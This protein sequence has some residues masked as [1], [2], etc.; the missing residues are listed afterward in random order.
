MRTNDI[1]DKGTVSRRT[2][3]KVFGAAAGLSAVGLPIRSTWAATPELGIVS[4]PGPSVSSHSKCII[5]ARD[6]D[7]KHGWNLQTIIRPTA[8]AYYNDFVTGVYGSIDFG[9]LSIFAKLYGK[10][11]PL[12]VVQ[13]TALW[14]SPVVVRA[15][16]GINKIQDLAGKRLGLQFGSFVYAY[17]S[18]AF[19]GAGMSLEKDVTAS[20]VGFFQAP[21]RFKAGDFDAVTMLFAHA[22]GL[23][24]EAPGT[25]KILMD[26][27]VAFAKAL[28]IERAY[29]YQAVRKDWLDANPGAIEQVI[30]TYAD[31]SHVFQTDAEAVVA[32]LAKAK[33][34]GGVGLAEKIG[35]VEYVTGTPD[36]LKIAWV[37][38]PVAP[39]QDG[40]M[41]ELEAYKKFGLIDSVPD[42]GLFYGIG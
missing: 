6:L 40:L 7:K 39:M 13:A 8:A 36:G 11:V 23:L 33:D 29:Q 15:D 42:K 17:M 35:K 3:L 9:G 2:A 16:S 34:V 21:P 24:Q 12:K 10:G 14:P 32:Q 18:G 19:Q 22:I 4:F 27:S 26:S 37:S 28:G 25:Y 31:L 20:N 5:K 38:R 1:H 30:K 41:K